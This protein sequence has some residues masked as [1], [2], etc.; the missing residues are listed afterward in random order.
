VS[1]FRASFGE[2]AFAI[3]TLRKKPKFIIDDPGPAAFEWFQMAVVESANSFL[4]SRDTRA[5][6]RIL[7]A[8]VSPP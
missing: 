7:S 6:S 1:K 4:P 8:N 2:P 3:E 5:C